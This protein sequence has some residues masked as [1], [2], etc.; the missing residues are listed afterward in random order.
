M[1][2]VPECPVCGEE[3]QDK[4]T[5]EQCSIPN[6]DYRYKLSYVYYI[7]CETCGYMTEEHYIKQEAVTDWTNYR[8]MI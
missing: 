6:P 3:D 5:L 2:I 4:I 1:M 7:G 8:T